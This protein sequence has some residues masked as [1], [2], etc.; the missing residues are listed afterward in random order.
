MNMEL[1]LASNSSCALNITSNQN[2]TI[3]TGPNGVYSSF[4]KDLFVFILYIITFLVASV[5]NLIVC[6]VCFVKRPKSTTFLLIANMSVSDLLSALL[7]PTQWFFCSTY[8]LDANERY[9]GSFKSLQVVSYY[10]STFTMAL[11]SFDR[12][13]ILKNPLS[14][15]VQP[16][17]SIVIIW[18]LSLFIS[19]PTLVAMRVSEYFTPLKLVHCRIIL[20]VDLKITGLI[21]K[22]RVLMVVVTQYV[23]PLTIA[24]TFYTLCIKKILS[25]QRIGECTDQQE[26]KFYQSKM[27][28][29]KMLVL[30]LSAFAIVNFDLQPDD[31]A[32]AFFCATLAASGTLKGD[33]HH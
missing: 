28:T 20:R 24:I 1:S 13:T 11:I 10:I 27:R 22:W 29:I 21:R 9:C 17:L 3:S 14:R 16:V 8:F 19:S 30:S 4:Y 7:I 6:Y 12:Y 26:I 33:H 18:M 15:R 32:A 2:C 23:I 25:R 31:F 5:G